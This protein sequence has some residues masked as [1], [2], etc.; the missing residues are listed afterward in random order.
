MRRINPDILKAKLISRER[1]DHELRGT[2]SKVKTKN[3]WGGIWEECLVNNQTVHSGVH[4]IVEVK[5][6]IYIYIY[7]RRVVNDTY[8]KYRR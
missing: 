6:Y 7:I 5:I 4:C 8:K 2:Q 3:E 1:S